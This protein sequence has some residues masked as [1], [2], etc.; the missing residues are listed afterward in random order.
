[1][2]AMEGW[3]MEYWGDMMCSTTAMVPREA[4]LNTHP[5]TP[6]LTVGAHAPLTLFLTFG[7]HARRRRPGE[8]C[9][10]YLPGTGERDVWQVRE[11]PL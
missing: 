5:L 10:A 2:G 9:A 7:V 6:T 4:T 11:V 8:D 3:A 1:M